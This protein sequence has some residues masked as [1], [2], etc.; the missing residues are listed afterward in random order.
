MHHGRARVV[1]NFIIFSFNIQVVVFWNEVWVVLLQTAWTCLNGCTLTR[2]QMSKQ[3][4]N[5]EGA[6]NQ[7]KK[8]RGYSSSL[9]SFS[10][11]KWD[12]RLYSIFLHVCTICRRLCHGGATYLSSI[13]LDREQ[14]S[15]RQQTVHLYGHVGGKKER[16]SSCFLLF[17]LF[18]FG[19]GKKEK[20]RAWAIQSGIE[21]GWHCA[22]YVHPMCAIQSILESVIKGPVYLPTNPTALLNQTCTLCTLCTLHMHLNS[23]T[24]NTG[25]GLFSSSHLASGVACL[26]QLL[27]FFCWFFERLNA[28]K[29]IDWCHVAWAVLAMCGMGNVLCAYHSS[30]FSHLNNFKIIIGVL[31]VQ[32]PTPRALPSAAFLGSKLRLRN[33][34]RPRQ[35]H[36]KVP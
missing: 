6:G 32:Q 21:D 5:L 15:C 29:R 7:T 8:R 9:P 31:L 3:R 27:C 28:S 30:Y 14:Q 11:R 19:P 12:Y 33:G 24:Y 2:M 23:W 10:L 13:G 35:H 25:N 36:P 4:C 20:K 16:T 26:P 17:S 1:S 18:F 34:R 22:R